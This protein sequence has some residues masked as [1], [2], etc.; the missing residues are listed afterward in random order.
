MIP[1][2]TSN[3]VLL[4]VSTQ[5]WTSDPKADFTGVRR[6]GH[7]AGR[8]DLKSGWTYRA[9]PVL[10]LSRRLFVHIKE[11]RHCRSHGFDARIIEFHANLAMKNLEQGAVPKLHDIVM[12]GKALVYKLPEVFSDRLASMPV[13]DTE[14]AFGILCEAIEA[15]AKRLVIDL[16]HIASSHSGG[17]VFVKVI[18]SI[19]SSWIT[20]LP[21]DHRGGC[22]ILRPA[23]QRAGPGALYGH[24][25][26]RSV[27]V[28]D[29]D[30]FLAH[31][32]RNCTDAS[33][34][35]GLP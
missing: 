10:D 33:R 14:I 34:A 26:G 19:L 9:Y 7:L 24:A 20:K 22:L 4:P 30:D 3:A 8:L 27:V 32:L 5:Q 13:G 6:R 17:A 16:F 2:A 15:F 31:L 1:C 11:M 23:C 18:V 12:R 29:A 35:I 28:G 21:P 25:A